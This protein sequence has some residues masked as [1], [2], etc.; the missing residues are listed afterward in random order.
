MASRD[1]SCQNTS[2]TVYSPDGWSYLNMISKYFASSI[3]SDEEPHYLDT[4]TDRARKIGF[5]MRR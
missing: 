2:L 3:E 5:E 4:Q 1:T